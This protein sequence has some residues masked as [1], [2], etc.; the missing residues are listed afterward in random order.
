MR[1]NE[2]NEMRQE[3]MEFSR[4]SVQRRLD[5]EW[6]REWRK[7]G[8]KEFQIAIDFSMNL[9]VFLPSTPYAPLFSLSL[10]RTYD[11]I[12]VDDEFGVLRFSILPTGW[13]RYINRIALCLFRLLSKILLML[14]ERL[15]FI[16]VYILSFIGSLF[17]GSNAL[18]S[19]HKKT[20]K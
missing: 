17:S 6:V 8:T 20:K 2:K 16:E 12:N 9:D 5:L 1:K 11:I 13:C 7:K 3:R 19:R 15:K 4:E 18:P 10:I 14:S